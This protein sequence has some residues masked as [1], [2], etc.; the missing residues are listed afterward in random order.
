MSFSSGI[1]LWYQNNKRDLPWRDIKN[2]YHIWL[3]EIILQQT[4]IIQ[5]LAYY[6]RFTSRFPDIHALANAS[7]DEVLAL[8][9][10]LGYY[11]RAR[12]MLHTAR[13]IT[14]Q[15]QGEFPRDY[16]T[17][18]SLKGIGSYTAAAICSLGFNQ[19]H[20]AVDGNVIRLITRYFGI[21][22]SP[23][24]SQVK[25]K[26]AQIANELIDTRHPGD[27][28][29][30]MMDLGSMICKPRKPACNLCPLRLECRAHALNLT[31]TI[32]LQKK[33]I[34]L[35]VRYFHFFYCWHVEN[36]ER[37][38]YI[39]KRTS[40]D[41]WKGL[42]QLPLY[43]SENP[44]FQTR[45]LSDHPLWRHINLPQPITAAPVIHLLTHQ[46]IEAL[47]Y[48]IHLEPVNYPIFE[49]QYQKVTDEEFNMMG[50]P[51]MISR[52]LEQLR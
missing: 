8:W 18:L 2:P 23:Q 34:P 6:E 41:I 12:N 17:L 39:E 44:D 40:N 13:V 22:E 11:S 30:A 52:F 19:P 25:N 42:Y 1:L 10:G 26:I 4:R 48:N 7:E 32:P 16:H 3:S 33:K 51:V 29:Q 24:N 28:N 35:R 46:R 47:F 27:F 20:A 37:V 50:K 43:E 49:L 31:E 5:G 15:Y 38:L 36:Q 14:A 45:Q 9:Q 21:E